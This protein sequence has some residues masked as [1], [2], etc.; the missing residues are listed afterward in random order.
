MNTSMSEIRN[1]SST[2]D[3]DEQQDI[4]DDDVGEGLTDDDRVSRE[5]DGEGD[6]ARVTLG[7]ADEERLNK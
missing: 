3:P 2:T 4:P 7:P 1:A 5:S 6:G